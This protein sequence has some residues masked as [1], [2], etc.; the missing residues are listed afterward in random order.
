MAKV[1]LFDLDGTLLP[2]DTESFIQNYI[3]ELAPRVAHIMEP[4]HFVKSLWAGTEAMIKNLDPKKTNEQVFEETFLTMTKL[5]KNDI[6]PTLD[7]FYEN[8]FPTF[9]HFTQPTSTAKKVVDEAFSQGYRVAIATNPVF[10]KV[11]I[12][13]RLNWA[14][15]ADMPFDMV[16]VYEESTFTKPHTHYYN[17]ICQRLKVT[18]EECIMVGNDVQ[19]DMVVSTIGMKTFLVDGF[20]I[21]RGT[22]SYAIDERGTLDELYHRLASRTGL[23]TK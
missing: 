11:A 4:N 2:M 23:F 16:T 6:W 21:D 8:I 22:Q 13:H 10:P 9:S 18:P 17:D 5:N 19:E 7:H 1:I 3:K 14:G 20:V 12:N 15:V